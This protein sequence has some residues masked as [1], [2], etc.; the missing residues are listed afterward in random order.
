MAL[1]V[2]VFPSSKLE[3]EVEGKKRE[4]KNAFT[5]RRLGYNKPG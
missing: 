5:G 3:V 4:A 1:V 2:D